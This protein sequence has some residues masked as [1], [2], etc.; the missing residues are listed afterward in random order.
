MPSETVGDPTCPPVLNF[1]SVWLFLGASENEYPTRVESWWN[2]GHSSGKT[3]LESS[4]PVKLETDINIIRI[5]NQKRRNFIY[6]LP[7]ACPLDRGCDPNSK[8][9]CVELL[10]FS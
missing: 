8:A 5:A 4:V 6:I 3:V 10:L 9:L 7:M 1:H 2:M